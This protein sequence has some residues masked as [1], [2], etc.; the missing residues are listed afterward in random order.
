MSSAFIFLYNVK[1]YSILW[2]SATK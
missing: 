1:N 2:R